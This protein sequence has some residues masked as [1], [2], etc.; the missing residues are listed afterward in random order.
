MDLE[1]Y[2]TSVTGYISKCVD[3]VTTTRTVT[4]CANQKPWLNAEIRSLLRTRDTAFRTGDMQSLREARR[5][6]TVGI[7]RAKAPYAQKIKGHFSSTDPGSM[8][9]GIKGISL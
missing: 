2:A 8:W 3:D 1:E 7:T 9:R 6:V 5:N 4:I